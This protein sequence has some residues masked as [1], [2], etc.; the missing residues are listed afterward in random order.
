MRE[1]SSHHC[2]ADEQH[3]ESL[4]LTDSTGIGDPLSCGSLMGARDDC[5]A[6]AVAELS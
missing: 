6:R 5:E 4:P 3:C 2:S 1:P